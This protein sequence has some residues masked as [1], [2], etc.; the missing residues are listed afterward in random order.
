[1][2][3]TGRVAVGGL[4]VDI[5]LS[6]DG[7][8][9]YVANQGPSAGVTI[10]S[11][12]TLRIVGFIPTGP[13]AHG[14]AISRNTRELY[15]ANRLAGTIS[16]ISFARRRVVATWHVGGSPDMLQVSPDGTELWASNRFNGTVS[17]IDTRTGRLIHTIVVG[18]SPHG[19]AY[20]PQPGNH[21]LGHNGVYR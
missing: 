7:T 8:L 21:R 15:A 3:V 9:F 12:R 5:K 16:V 2:R 6:P 13:G 11:A 19:L 4:P 18:S 20:F 14:L 1:M 17:V 10:I